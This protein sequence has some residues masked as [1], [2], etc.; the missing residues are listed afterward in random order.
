MLYVCY[1]GK[2]VTLTGDGRFDSPGHSARYCHYMLI[3][4]VSNNTLTFIATICKFGAADFG[5]ELHR[6]YTSRNLQ[7]INMKIASKSQL[8]S[9]FS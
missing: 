1:L 7:Q 4:Y 3:D 8:K 2:P 5:S 6:V 9:H